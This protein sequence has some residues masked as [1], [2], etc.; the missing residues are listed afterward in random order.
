MENQATPNDMDL[1]K[2]YDWG[3]KVI[4]IAEDVE[5][6]KR[7][8][9]AALNR[10]NA[11]LLWAKNGKEAVDLVKK[12]KKIDIILMDL[13]MPE[14]NGFKATRII[15]NINKD[16]PIIVQTAYILAGEEEMSYEAGCDEFL[17]KPIKFNTLLTTIGKYF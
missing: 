1:Q 16:I 9:K 8:F 5:T 15:K 4:L 7:Y 13:H 14:L 17:A 10:T 6:S 3:N 12:N 11:K 2:N